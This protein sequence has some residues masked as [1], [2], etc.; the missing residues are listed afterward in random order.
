MN[1]WPEDQKYRASL[2]QNPV[3]VYYEQEKEV[4]NATAHFSSLPSVD[5]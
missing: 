3:P 1:G 5:L 4:E 2:V